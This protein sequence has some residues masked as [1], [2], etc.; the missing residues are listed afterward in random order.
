MGKFLFPGIFDGEHH[1]E[2]I[3]HGNGTCT[4][5]QSEKF[6]G[7]LVGMINLENTQRGFESMNQ[8]L[9][10]RSES[11]VSEPGR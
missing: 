1:F 4:F 2:I 7:I 3:D 10:E 5:K 6:S 9:K 8:K 11:R